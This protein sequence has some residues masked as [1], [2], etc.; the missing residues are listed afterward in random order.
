MT[1]AAAEAISFQVRSEDGAAR[2]GRLVTGHGVIDTPA[3]MPVGTAAAVKALTPAQVAATGARMVLANTYHLY[4]RPGHERIARLGGL[5]RFMGWDG[6]ML[7]DSGGYQVFSLADLRTLDQEGV[8]F[9][10]HL[11]GSTHRFTAD[12]A[13]EVQRALGADVVMAFDHCPALPAAQGEV[14]LAVERTTAWARRSLDAFGARRRHP[15]GHEQVLFGIVQGGLDASLRSRSAAALIELDLPGY[16]IGGLSVGETKEQMQGAVAITAPLLPQA[17][18]RY[19]MGVGFP[20]DILAAVAA[21]VDLFDCVLPTR[22]ARNG[23][24]LTREGRL[25]LRNRRFADDPRPLDARCRCEACARFSRA[26]LRHLVMAGEILASVLCT[27]H[28]VTFYQDLMAEIRAAV[29]QRQ[30]AAFA[31]EFLAKWAAGSTP[32]A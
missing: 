5:H 9:R 2:R 27:V 21:G 24:A 32:W 22:M 19:L 4:L 11:D 30:L 16:A 15:A 10:S 13:M 7:T 31:R 3:F 29:E 26:Y 12:L 1:D 20:E 17:K 14:A 6:A 25:P 8:T 23:T 18:P 28:N